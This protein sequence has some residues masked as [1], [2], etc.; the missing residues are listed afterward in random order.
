[1]KPPRCCRPLAGAAPLG[2]TIAALRERLAQSQAQDQTALQERAA[3]MQT[4]SALLA[5]LQ[6]AAAE[7]RAAIDGLVQSA[8]QQLG[9]ASRQFGEHAAQAGANMARAAEQTPSARA[10]ARARSAR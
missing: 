6:H 10:P 4:L 5:S 8:G 9:D 2:D 7:Q 1:M 3:L